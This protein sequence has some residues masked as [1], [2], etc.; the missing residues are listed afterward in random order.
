MCHAHLSL[1]LMLALIEGCGFADFARVSVN[2]PITMEDVAFIRPD[3]TTFAEV[4]DKLGT[5]DELVESET[6]VIV[7]YRFLDARY[8]RINYGSLASPWSP[9]TPD[10]ITEGLGMRLHRLN[11]RLSPTWVV[12]R[13]DFTDQ[14]DRPSGFNLVPFVR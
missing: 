4:I 10:V 9:V 2:E 7:V 14:Q 11:I 1:F 13:T 12:Q 6:G 8:S 3:Q 5:P